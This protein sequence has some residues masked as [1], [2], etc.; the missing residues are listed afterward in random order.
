MQTTKP[1]LLVEDDDL[2]AAIMR[3]ALKQLNIQNQLVRTTDG[4]E[5]L[6]YLRDC[7]GSLP[8]LVLLD[9]NMPRMGGLEFL[10]RIRTDT[11]LGAI[12]VIVVT[13]SSV[14]EDVDACLRLGA[15]DYIRKD[16]S[17]EIFVAD[18]RRIERHCI[19]TSAESAV[20]A[21]TRASPEC[22]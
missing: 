16:C 5:A 20:S 6:E 12:P 11:R 13:T 4:E 1:L 18:M 21:E 8:C 14:A 22:H 3:R 2:D 19:H 15:A 17:F 9:L 7:P 10:E